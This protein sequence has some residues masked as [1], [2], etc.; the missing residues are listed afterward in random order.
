MSL[1]WNPWHGCQKIS[2]GCANCYVYRIDGK[3]GR[4]SSLVTMTRSFDLPV[5]RKRNGAYKVPPGEEVFCCFSS[6]F[7]LD[8]ADAWRPMAWKMIHERSDCHFFIITKRIDRFHIGLP[9]D[10]AD[11]YDNVTIGATIENQD[12]ADHRLPI[13][14]KAPIKHKLIICEPLLGHLDIERYL[15]S[16]VE[17]VIAGGES[18]DDARIC[19]YDWVLDISRQCRQKDVPFHFKQT[20]AK[21]LKDGHVYNIRRQ[22]QHSQAKKAGIDHN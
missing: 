14:F 7:F 15:G 4:D 13:F 21:L 20:G 11:G 5:K 6:D 18:G 1:T 22:Y 17:Q 16:W 12:R 9:E 2:E 19:N 3:H 8:D 10:W